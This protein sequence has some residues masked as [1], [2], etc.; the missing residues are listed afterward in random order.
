MTK[1]VKLTD[2]ERELLCEL[3]H[4]MEAG[5]WSAGDYCLTQ[6]QFNALENAKRKLE[7]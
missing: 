3:I 6:R 4:I 2:Q 1:A 5:E 7:E